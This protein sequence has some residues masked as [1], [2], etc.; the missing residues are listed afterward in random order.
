MKTAKEKKLLKQKELK[1]YQMKVRNKYEDLRQKGYGKTD[2]KSLCAD[3]F[4][5]SYA[6]VNNYIRVTENIE[7]V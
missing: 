7:E 3:H 6:T 1:A 4:N 5:L 2:A